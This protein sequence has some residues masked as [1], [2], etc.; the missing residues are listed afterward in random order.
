[1]TWNQDRESIIAAA[2]LGD[3]T[4]R[5]AA[6]LLVAARKRAFE[7]EQAIRRVDEAYKAV[8]DRLRSDLV[9]RTS[10][11]DTAR[12][13]L[14]SLRYNLMAV[15]AQEKERTDQL[16][17]AEAACR[18]DATALGAL[19]TELSTLKAAHAW[20]KTS[21][22]MPAHGDRCLVYAD[23]AG[24]VLCAI[25]RYIP[26]GASD[27]RP[28]QIQHGQERFLYAGTEAIVGWMPLPEAPK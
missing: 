10:E 28:W 14:K 18:R 22:R 19:Q 17:M 26:Y 11:R 12:D 21:E 4:P 1:M 13:E 2:E 8:A 7:A 23:F 25:G 24:T 9:Q 15:T 16:A 6:D 3:A 27:L 5:I 20:I